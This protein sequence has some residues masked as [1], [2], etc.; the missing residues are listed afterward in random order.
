MILSLI[1]GEKKIAYIKGGKY[2]D[3]FIYIKDGSKEDS[4][5][6]SDS[7][8]EYEPETPN[9]YIDEK[10]Y[11]NLLNKR[12]NRETKFD[13]I[14]PLRAALEKKNSSKLPEH[15]KEFFKKA[16]NE[17]KK[18][19]QKELII[20]DG[21]VY[22]LPQKIKDQ[23][24]Y[25]YIAGPSGS[26]KSSFV[27]N[28]AS[29]Y[30]KLNKNNSIWLFSSV[31]ED[32][33]LEGLDVNQMALDKGLLKDGGMEASE[34]I[35]KGDGAM[36]IFDDIDMIKDKEINK[37]VHRIRDTLLETGR[38][39]NIS[40]VCTGHQ[41]M[42][43]KKTRTVLNE[44][45]GVVFFPKAGSQYHITRFLKVYCG[46]SSDQIK[47]ILSLNSRWIFVNKSYPNYVL[48]Q[49]GAIIF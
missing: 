45:T 13:Y 43:Y 35:E 28:Y 20:D 38:H 14:E 49:H 24:N 48:Y 32:K 11:K 34:F 31:N 19:S 16:N 33:A 6:D 29:L 9:D 2:N 12:S 7:E 40:V 39:K 21:L 10:F 17:L 41:L 18:K 23:V 8:V 44:A 5:N 27:S 1:S 26:G 36:V 22:P 37:E 4:D 42:D 15:L 25:I 3:R 46:F 30:K 47:K